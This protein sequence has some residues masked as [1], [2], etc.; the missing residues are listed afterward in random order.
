MVHVFWSL[1]VR[2]CGSPPQRVLGAS[3]VEPG[4]WS[5]EVSWWRVFCLRKEF[6]ANSELFTMNIV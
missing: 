5:A 1:E 3:S 2:C 4:I 6:V